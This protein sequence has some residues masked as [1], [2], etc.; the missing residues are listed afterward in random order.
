MLKLLTSFKGLLI[1]DLKSCNQIAASFIH[2]SSALGGKL[3]TRN[4]GPKKFI[5]YNKVI[6]EPQLPEEKP[7]PA[8]SRSLQRLTRF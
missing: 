6:Y 8:V 2:T 1:N 7:R 4:K 3:N 5:N